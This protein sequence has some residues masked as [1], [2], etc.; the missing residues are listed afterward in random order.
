M[1]LSEESDDNAEKRFEDLC[2]DLNMDTTSK[3][4]AWEAF[5]RISQNY[6]LEVGDAVMAAMFCFKTHDASC[7]IDEY[8]C[9]NTTYSCDIGQEDG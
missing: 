7:F 9:Y 6:T 2:L 1:G 4:E 5:Q 8:L 3:E